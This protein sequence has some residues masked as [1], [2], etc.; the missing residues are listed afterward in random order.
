MK[1]AT[2]RS[3][4]ILA[5]GLKLF[6]LGLIIYVFVL[7]I[8][9][10]W[11]VL[12]VLRGIDADASVVVRYVSPGRLHLSDVTL[13]SPPWFRAEEIAVTYGPLGLL[14]GRVETVTIRG[15]EWHILVRD[16]AVDLGIST[17]PSSGSTGPLD[18]AFGLIELHDA[19]IVL[20]TEDRSFRLP[21]VVTMTELSPYEQELSIRADGVDLTSFAPWTEFHSGD[22]KLEAIIRR[23][24]IA[25]LNAELYIP[26]IVVQGQ[27]LRDA[28]IQLK[29]TDRSGLSV[30]QASASDQDLGHISIEGTI[31]S[32]M[33]LFDREDGWSASAELKASIGLPTDTRNWLYEHGIVVKVGETVDCTSQAV[34]QF[35]MD[36][37]RALPSWSLQLTSGQAEISNCSVVLPDI[38]VE[39]LGLAGQ[40]AFEMEIDPDESSVRFLAGSN[41]SVQYINGYKAGVSAR[42]KDADSPLTTLT[43]GPDS[44]LL[45]MTTDAPAS[46]WRVSGPLQ[47][48]LHECDL[49]ASPESVGTLTAE[50]LDVQLDVE[51]NA[52][53]THFT[54]TQRRVGSMTIGS[55]T[56]DHDEVSISGPL[57]ATIDSVGDDPLIAIPSNGDGWCAALGI[58]FID[59]VSIESDEVHAM[60]DRLELISRVCLNQDQEQIL[61]ATA[62]FADS[63]V[64]LTSP[65][66]DFKGIA[67]TLPLA[68]GNSLEKAG[69]FM[70]ADVSH[71]GVQLGS[72]E[73]HIRLQDELAVITADIDFLAVVNVSAQGQLG[74]GE[75]G[76][77]GEFH[78]EAPRFTISDPT[79]FARLLGLQARAELGGTLSM[80]A[81]VT[82][83]GNDVSARGSLELI[84]VNLEIPDEELEVKGINGK[85]MFNQL[86]PLTTPGGQQLTIAS[87]SIG[88][89][90]VQDAAIDYTLEGSNALL[91]ESAQWKTDDEAQ[92]RATAFRFDPFAPVIST[93]LY[94]EDL[95][96]NYWLPLLTDGR[97]TGEGTLNGHVTFIIRPSRIWLGQGYFHAASGGGRISVSDNGAL[98]KLLKQ[99]DTRFGTDKNLQIVKQRLIEALRD[100]RYDT[101]QFDLLTEKQGT[102]LRAFTSGRGLHGESPQ[103]IG[104]LTVNIPNIDVVLSQL[105]SLRSALD[106]AA[107]RSLERFFD[108]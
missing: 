29:Q 43:I 17:E 11:Q 94:A 13:G 70:V 103:E 60:I 2:H 93:T 74:W 21:V 18:G 41:L 30:F 73:G 12:A 65:D 54:V 83:N 100:F 49:V 53:P 71:S 32:L 25:Q 96:L 88:R 99:S 97:A 57:R 107:D 89:L 27:V 101:L 92:F 22:L 56:S 55:I 67:A 86:W 8:L 58:N 10:R 5:A 59:T 20:E 47:L 48:R 51:V 62:T 40:I 69:S 104:G 9:A 80:F 68:I 81:D 24:E 3:R 38:G 19:E 6:F 31:P 91:V 77:S 33:D 79:E 76:L 42:T 34:F 108:E 75:S 15:A 35:G 28:K 98:D 36:S 106:Y 82:I 26:R 72:I 87:A 46:S 84:D 1:R 45:S 61:N 95:N 105:L 64:Y 4:R 78:A 44:C 23:G 39:L 63:S 85:V 66:L 50:N 102:T 16:G 7:P 37:D 90:S 52:D 14:S